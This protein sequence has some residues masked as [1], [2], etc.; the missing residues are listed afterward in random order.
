MVLVILGT[1]TAF[2]EFC[3]LPVTSFSTSDEPG[4]DAPYAVRSCDLNGDGRPDL[5]TAND[6]TDTVS[7]LIN[8]GSGFAP[9]VRWPVDL[10]AGVV[11]EPVHVACCDVNGDGRI[12]LITVNHTSDDISVLLNTGGTN[13]GAPV[14]YSVGEAP[15]GIECIDL[16]GDARPDVLTNGFTADSVSVLINNGVGGFLAHVPYATGDAPIAMALCD[17]DGDAKPDVVTANLLGKSVTVLRNNGNGTLTSLGTTPICRTPADC[18]NPFDI[19]CCDLDQAGGPDVITANGIDDSVAVLFNNGVGAL[20]GLETYQ[21]VDGAYGV[22]CCDLTGD[23]SIDVVT[24]NLVSDDLAVFVNAG[25]GILGAPTQIELGVNAEPS[26]VACVNV[27]DDNDEDIVATYAA[28]LALIRNDCEGEVI[29]A[30]S[31]WGMVCLLLALLIVGS[32]LAGR[33]RSALSGCTGSAYG[34]GR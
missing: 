33:Q 27:D 18:I 9:K 10:D 12:D 25:N 16:N 6:G 24:A 14:K 29:P 13:Y 19:A 23:G 2:A 4:G 5:I 15:L 34:T 21:P 3:P 26:S 28:G 30:I 22:A 31:Q 1:D 20:G 32:I 17:M 8:T 7:V 11:S